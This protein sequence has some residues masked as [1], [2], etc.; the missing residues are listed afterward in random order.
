MK[1]FY[2]LCCFSFVFGLMSCKQDAATQQAVET[3]AAAGDTVAT[4]TQQAPGQQAPK[5]DAIKPAI[6]GH[7]YTFLT[8]KILL[9]KA[10]FGGEKS[11]QEQ[12]FKDEWIDLQTDGTYKAGKLKQQT[13]T[14]KWSYNHD[15]QTLYLGPDTK[16]FKRSEWKVM[17]NDQMMVWVGTQTYG[18]NAIQIKLVKSETLPE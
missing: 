12:P 1:S 7:D 10:A 4:P 5:E 15:T 16:G 2:I 6:Q 11:A 9:Y 13:H 18:D 14:G 17:H 8:E 3:P